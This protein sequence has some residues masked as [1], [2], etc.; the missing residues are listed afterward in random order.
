MIFFRCIT[1]FVNQKSIDYN[2]LLYEHTRVSSFLAK[3]AIFSKP[4]GKEIKKNS[5]FRSHLSSTCIMIMCIASDSKKKL[6]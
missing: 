3:S 6:L 2:L 1:Y 4:Q 5:I